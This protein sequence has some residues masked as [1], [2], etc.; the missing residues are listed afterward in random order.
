MTKIA[1]SGTESGPNPLVRGMDP[2]IRIH[3]KCLR[4]ATLVIG[5]LDGGGADMLPAHLTALWLRQL[6]EETV[7]LL[8]YHLL[9]YSYF[10]KK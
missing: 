3:T 6:G 9:N 7:S 2:R 5:Y 1:G 8:L 10:V 4:S